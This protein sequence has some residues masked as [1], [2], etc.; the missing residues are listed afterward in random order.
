MDPVIHIYIHSFPHIN[1]CPFACLNTT[2]KELEIKETDQEEL[3][4]KGEKILENK[5]II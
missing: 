2:Q 3:S 5:I 1:A 4:K